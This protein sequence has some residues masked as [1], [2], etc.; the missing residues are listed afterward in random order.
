MTVEQFLIRMKQRNTVKLMEGN[1]NLIQ[2]LD[3]KMDCTDDGAFYYLYRHTI[4]I[5]LGD[6]FTLI[7][8]RDGI[9]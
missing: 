7:P 9:K 2:H 8:I 3:Q 5:W 1:P 4:H 6:G